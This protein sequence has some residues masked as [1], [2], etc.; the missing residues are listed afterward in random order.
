M[1]IFKTNIKATNYNLHS[2]VE[3]YIDKQISRFQKVLPADSHVILDVEIGRLSKY[4]RPGHIFRAEFN[5]M[6][7]GKLFRA[8]EKGESIKSAIRLAADDM[9]RQVRKTSEKQTDLVRR[10]AMKIKS[11]MKFGK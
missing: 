3:E 4:E 5:L 11:W 8:E 6:H 10:G 1:A 9:V 2:E 7:A